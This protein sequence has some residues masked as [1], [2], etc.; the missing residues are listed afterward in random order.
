MD[1]NCDG[2]ISVATPAALCAAHLN[3]EGENTRAWLPGKSGLSGILV[4]TLTYDEALP[5]CTPLAD[6]LPINLRGVNLNPGADPEDTVPV[7]MYIN[8][9]RVRMVTVRRHRMMA[10]HDIRE[11]IAV[12]KGPLAKTMKRNMYMLSVIATIFLPL[13]LLTGL[14]GINVGGISGVDWKWVFTI[15]T[16]GIL[17]IGIAGYFLMHRLRWV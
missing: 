2:P 7:R 1:A 13:S 4:E 17:V 8:A 14:L 3:L 12:G 5:C 15:V 6:G 9:Q 16:P 11:P 10:V